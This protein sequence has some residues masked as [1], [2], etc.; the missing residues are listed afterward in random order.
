MIIPELNADHARIIPAQRARL[1]TKRGFIAVKS[2]CSIQSY[3]PLLTP[4][5]AGGL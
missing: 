1:G 4:P 2:N 5:D 3:A